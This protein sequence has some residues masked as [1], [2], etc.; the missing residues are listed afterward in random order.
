MARSP[1]SFEKR[2]RERLKQR[3]REEK[4]ARKL[5]RNEEKKRAKEEG[6]ERPGD[7]DDVVD[8]KLW[9]EDEDEG[10]AEETE[11]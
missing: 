7:W 5:E 1:Q 4:L 9:L 11:G 8:P 6:T 3:K 2:Q 10:E